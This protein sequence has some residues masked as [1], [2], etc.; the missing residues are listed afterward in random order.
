MWSCC[1]GVAEL[2][3]YDSAEVHELKK[4]VSAVHQP[5]FHQLHAWDDVM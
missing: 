1:V 3:H 4:L 2:V 5:S